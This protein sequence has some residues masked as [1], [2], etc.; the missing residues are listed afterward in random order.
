M[1]SFWDERYGEAAFVYGVEPNEF[2][3]SA[4]QWLPAGGSILSLGEGE[5]RNALFLAKAGHQVVAVDQSDV[6]LAKA[7]RLAREA[8]CSIATQAADLADFD[9]GEQRYD[10]IVS[11]FCHLPATLRQSIHASI[12]RGL[13]DGGLFIT[14][15]YAPE[16]LQYDSG[17]PKDGDMLVSLDE[18]TREFADFEQLHAFTGT[19]EVNEGEFH[20]GLAAVTQFVRRSGDSQDW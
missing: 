15:S 16:Q 2:L 1:K 14:E 19:R 9:L 5:G 11:I 3:V 10:A 4:A 20:R 7:A 12:K 8:G 6:G 13:R 18:L 17:G